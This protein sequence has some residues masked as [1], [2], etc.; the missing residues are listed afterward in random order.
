MVRFV[1][2]GRP[3]PKARPRMAVR[4]NRAYVY[5]SEKT[6]EYEELVGLYAKQHVN[7]PL[8]CPV[9]AEIILYF[10]KGRTPDLDNCLKSILDGLNKVVYEDDCQVKRIK[11]EI[12]KDE[13]ERADITIRELRKE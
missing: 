2:P 13:F 1:V 9:E 5:T 4:G 6:R 10:H 3:C 11:A 12:R 8:K 7:K